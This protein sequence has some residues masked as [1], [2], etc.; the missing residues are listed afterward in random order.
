M[1]TSLFPLVV[2]KSF[3]EIKQVQEAQETKK[4]HLQEV[5]T[6]NK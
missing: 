1:L 2:G 5:V 4:L 6:I 3:N